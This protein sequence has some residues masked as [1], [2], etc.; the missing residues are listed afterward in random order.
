MDRINPLP[1]RDAWLGHSAADLGKSCFHARMLEGIHATLGADHFTHLSYD[2]CGKI[3]TAAA[4]SMLDQSLIDAT[5]D[6]YVNQLY[7][8]DPNYPLVCENSKEVPGSLIAL[9]LLWF[10]PTNM[11]DSEYRRRLF[12]EPGFTS[13]VS[14]LGQWTE[15]SCYLNFYFSRVPLDVARAKELLAGY[16][17]TLMNLA[18]R[19]DELMY[20]LSS[21]PH[22]SW[23][24]LSPRERE[25]A[26]LLMRGRTTKEIG[27]QMALSPATVVTYKERLYAKLGV[28]GLREFLAQ[29]SKDLV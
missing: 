22:E 2:P 5:T 17:S 11:G 16:G 3:R 10:S 28:A 7:M 13:K 4:A 27:R 29:G 9:R 26:E 15:G 18:H 24:A 25:T 1:T 6:I 23:A 19:H 14:L 12:E 20:S 8:R 21:P